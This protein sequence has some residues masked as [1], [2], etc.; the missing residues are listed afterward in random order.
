MKDVKL[1]YKFQKEDKRD[2][3]LTHQVFS[4]FPPQFDVRDKYNKHPPVFSQL[5]LGSCTAQATALAYILHLKKQKIPSFIPSRCY[6]YAN[7]RLLVGTD[8][9][10]DSGADLR[11]V[12]RAVDKYDVCEEPQWPYEQKNWFARPTPACYA[13]AKKHSTFQ[14]LSVI[15]GMKN[16]KQALFDG[17]G[18]VFGIMVYES[19]MTDKVAETGIAPLPDVKKEACVG[20]HAI[21]LIGWDD[22]K[23]AF[24]AQNSW[25]TEF[26]IKGC[27]YLPYE[28]VL[29]PDLASDFLVMEN[30][31]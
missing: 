14:Y 15:Q 25:G 29:N 13:A 27:F 4:T 19:L 23:N 18:V 17:N 28:Y 1:N 22:A 8:L 26:G 16:L 21:C 20:G 3:K 6:I 2:Y 5:Q 31:S 9:S 7:S 11:D 30:V 24:L 10:D 12:M